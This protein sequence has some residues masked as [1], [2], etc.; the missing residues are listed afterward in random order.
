M[1]NHVN[2]VDSVEGKVQLVDDISEILTKEKSIDIREKKLVDDLKLSNS[3]AKE[4]AKSAGFLHI[5]L[6][7][8]R[9]LI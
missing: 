1:Q 8:L 5:I 6:C 7:H 9:L 3:L 2:E 4:I